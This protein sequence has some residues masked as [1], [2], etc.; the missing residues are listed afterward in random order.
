MVRQLDKGA[1]RQGS[2][3]QEEKQL[4]KARGQEAQTSEHLN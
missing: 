1:D 3:L 2:I 4:K